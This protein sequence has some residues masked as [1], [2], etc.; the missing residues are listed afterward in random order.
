MGAT[1]ER[2]ISLKDNRI[3]TE[4]LAGSISR[5]ESAIE[6]LALEQTLMK[7]R[8]ERSE[9]NFVVEDIRNNLKQFV[10]RVDPFRRPVVK[11]L[12]NV[13]HLYTPKIGRASC[14]EKVEI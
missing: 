8:K 6:D 11:K 5:G 1:P 7:S 3:L 12:H 9:H 14:K 4:G 2:L 13:Q 10:L